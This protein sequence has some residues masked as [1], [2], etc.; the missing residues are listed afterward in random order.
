MA[1]LDVWVV[2][3]LVGNRSN[4]LHQCCARTEPTCV[5]PYDEPVVHQAPA[6][7]PLVVD[8]LTC[9]RPLVGLADRQ[10]ST[11]PRMASLVSIR[12]RTRSSGSGSLIA[13]CSEPLVCS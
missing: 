3:D 12:L 9:Q 8:L 6:I 7:K 11:L 13:K 1:Q 4:A 10:V 5:E 2:V